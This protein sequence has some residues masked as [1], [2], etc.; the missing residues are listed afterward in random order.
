MNIKQTH[1]HKADNPGCCLQSPFS[2][3]ESLATGGECVFPKLLGFLWSSLPSP[4]CPPITHLYERVHQSPSL[5]LS[6]C[7]ILTQ[8]WCHFFQD[9]C[10]QLSFCINASLATWLSARASTSQEGYHIELMYVHTRCC[11]REFPR[12]YTERA[13]SAPTSGHLKDCNTQLAEFKETRSQRWG[14]WES[15][16]DTPLGKAKHQILVERRTAKNISIRQLWET[17]YQEWD[18]SH[19]ENHS[20]NVA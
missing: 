3:M 6:D 12:K 11:Y 14:E 7:Y 4:H 8:I 18:K 1:A 17:Y 10:H 2:E 15:L 19:H 9:T 20:I 5:S 13:Y 16:I